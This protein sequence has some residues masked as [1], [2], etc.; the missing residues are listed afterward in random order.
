MIST[1]KKMFVVVATAVFTVSCNAAEVVAVFDGDTLE[2]L[3]NGKPLRI[4][5][6]NIDAPE[7]SQPFGQASKKSLSDMCYG[8]DATYTAQSKQGVDKY[9]RTIA[10]VKCAGIE[11]NRAQIERGLAWV[12]TAYNNDVTLHTIEL[13]AKMTRIGLWHDVVPVAPW[14]YRHNSELRTP[15]T[16]LS[17]QTA[18][19]VGPRG[20]HYRIV[21]GEKRYGC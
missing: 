18:C 5:L 16:A 9:N 10:V 6:A 7:K 21:N 12:Y 15:T 19:F 8:K 3:E 4:R 20:G 11:V 17:K 1:V 2:V 14:E 13:N